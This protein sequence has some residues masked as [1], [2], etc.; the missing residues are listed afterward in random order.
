MT[1]WPTS[2]LGD[3]LSQRLGEYAIS[4]PARETYV[5]VRLYGR[6]AIKRKIDEGKTPSMRS[7][8]RIR[9][10]DLIY[11]RIDARNGAFAIVPLELDGAVVSKDFPNFRVRSD[12]TDP[13]FLIRFLSTKRFFAQLRGAS[14]GT[15]NRQRISEEKLLA[16][17][18]P[19]P[20]IEDQR[21]IAQILDEA[22]ALRKLR[23]LADERTGALISAIYHDMFGDPLANPKGWEI[24]PVGKFVSDLFGGRNVNPA[25]SDDATDGLRVLK[26]SSVTSG[27]F[28]PEE[29]KP[30]PAGCK[31]PSAHFVQKDDLLFSRANTTELVGATAYVF[32]QP[33]MLLLPDK[34]WRLVW[35]EPKIVEPLFI[36]RLFQT[37]SMRR[38]LGKRAT[39]TSGSMKNISKP[40]L[41]TLNVPIPPLELQ[42]AFVQKFLEIKELEKV[43]RRSGKELTIL[44]DS[45]LHKAYAG[46]L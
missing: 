3:V 23:S 18:I 1:Y 43:Q 9:A 32:S 35:K 6:G 17:H 38:E 44:L 8:Y 41:L 25:G 42:R 37:T 14:F 28:R 46:E 26:V 5:T 29:S 31:A 11:S 15:T 27:D 16:F 21:R 4:D 39:G 24:Q 30:V 33:S 2:P 22:D 45:L 20:P 19:T 12:R 40:K 10:G 7:G 36:W 13:R 34:L